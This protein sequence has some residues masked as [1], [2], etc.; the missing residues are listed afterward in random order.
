MGGASTR[1]LTPALSQRERGQNAADCQPRVSAHESVVAGLLL[2][3]LPAPERH[4]Y[5]ERG[6]G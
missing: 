3:A 6:D 2:K 4:G 5:A 1:T